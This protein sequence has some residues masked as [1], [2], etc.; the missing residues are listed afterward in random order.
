M[1]TKKLEALET[2][3]MGLGDGTRESTGSSLSGNRDGSSGE[4]VSEERGYL[5]D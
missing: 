4:G 1:R 5:A 2:G 3:T